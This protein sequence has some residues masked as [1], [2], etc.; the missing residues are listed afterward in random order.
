[1]VLS[2]NDSFDVTPTLRS[3][4]SGRVLINGAKIYVAPKDMAKR[5]Q[6]RKAAVRPKPSVNKRAMQ[7][8]TEEA[9]CNADDEETTETG[10]DV[11]KTKNKKKEGNS[12]SGDF[13]TLVI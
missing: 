3:G 9:E 4:A 2:D 5:G 11:S 12:F 13:G 10:I 1:M 7:I 6:K 8:S